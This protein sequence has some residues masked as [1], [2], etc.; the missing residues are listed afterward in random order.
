MAEFVPAYWKT[1]LDDV[2][3]ELAQVKKGKVHTL[4]PSA[5][6]RTIQMVEYGES[7]LP[8]ATANLSS[9]LGAHDIRCYADK[10]APDYRPTVFFAGCIHGGEFEGTS[11]L[12]N[13]IHLLETG[14][15]YKGE[16]HPEL[17]KNA[18]KLHLVL[19]PM[20]NPDGRTHIPFDNF[21]GRTQYDLRYY[22]Q[23]TWK[24]GSLCGWPGCKKVAPIKEY[25]DYLG[26]YFN[27]DG[28]NMMHD[29]FF[30]HPSAEVQN[31]LDI[32]REYAPDISV[33]F[34]GGGN[35]SNHITTAGY[36][37]YSAREQTCEVIRRTLAAYEPFGIPFI[38]NRTAQLSYE[39]EKRENPIS[40]NLISAMHHCCGAMC[41]TFESNQGLVEA[42]Q[43]GW[44]NE[45]IYLA[46]RLFFG[47][48]FEMFA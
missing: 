47:A 17:V 27:D 5:G 39:K 42:P 16:E 19:L 45:Q 34:H 18:E 33:L 37:S 14:K 40:F 2:E 25:V 24:D 13:L 6:G 32:C 21:V 44:D 46:H 4:R 23:G 26:G 15:D 43:P 11:A 30:S 22:N 28:V 8:P 1:T 31:V 7:N 12:L 41:L 38:D 9:A 20:C 10:T 36:V 29:E 48:V 35:S 3:R